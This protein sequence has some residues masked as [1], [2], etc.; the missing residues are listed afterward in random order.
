MDR[1]LIFLDID[2]TLAKGNSIT[3]EN[4]SAISRAR[5]KGHLV[6]I[7]TGRSYGV[8]Q[9]RVLSLEVDGFVCGLGT[10]IRYNGEVVKSVKMDLGLAEEIAA[11][12]FDN[13]LR[14][15]FECE[16]GA[17]YMNIKHEN[18]I[19][20]AAEI[21]SRFGKWRISKLT[22]FEE[23]TDADFEY[24][25]RFFTV[26]RYKTYSE[27]V[28]KGYSKVRGMR[29]LE[30]LFGIPRAHIMAIGDS[31][32]DA[33]MIEYAG[34]GVA[35]GN[36]EVALKQSAFWITDTVDNSGVARAIEKFIPGLK[37]AV[38]DGGEK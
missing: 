33:E 24:F 9:E 7:N 12:I 1:Y 26:Y 16:E 10:Y 27:G 23:I 25:S 6:F 13:S 37:C 28:K 15:C 17:I 36:A 30:N 4:I 32:N 20:S 31:A 11:Y 8:V 5:E 18:E 14:A 35:M 29:A 19:S 3:E 38:T 2:G 21:S 34:I 22:V